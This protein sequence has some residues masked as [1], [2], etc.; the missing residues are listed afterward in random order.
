METIETIVHPYTLLVSASIYVCMWRY[1]GRW[2]LFVLSAA[3]VVLLLLVVVVVLP[4]LV[5][6]C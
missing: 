2:V 4:L 6:C 1:P 3:V 5:G